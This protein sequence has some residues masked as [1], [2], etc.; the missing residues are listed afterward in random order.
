ML[1]KP[2]HRNSNS[3]VRE[4]FF[5]LRGKFLE[6]LRLENE[7]FLCLYEILFVFFKSGGGGPCPCSHWAELIKLLW[8]KTCQFFILQLLMENASI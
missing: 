8:Y 2:C 7:N 5:S 6:V 1:P 3:L 4:W